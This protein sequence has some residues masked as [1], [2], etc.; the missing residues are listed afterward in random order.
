MRSDHLNKHMKIHQKPPSQDGQE[1]STVQEDNKRQKNKD[2]VPSSPSS[3]SSTSE[4]PLQGS[5]PVAENDFELG[6]SY[7]DI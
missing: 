3:L 4:T 7:A 2:P 5:I 6:M 1:E